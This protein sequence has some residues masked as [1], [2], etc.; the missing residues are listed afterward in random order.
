MA[1][2]ATSPDAPLP[3]PGEIE[4]ILFDLDDTLVDA[5]GSWRAGFAEA[6]AGLHARSPALQRLGSPA[7]IYDGWF[8]RYGEE[9]HRAAGYGE[10]RPGFTSEAFERLVAEHLGPDPALAADLVARYRVAAPR[11][12]AIYPDAEPLL[13][14]LGARYPLG[15]I[16]NG[17]S[18]LQRPKIEQFA[19]ERY[20]EVLVVSGEFGVRKPDPLIFATALEALGVA[21]GRAV[22]IGDNPA[23]DIAG[24]RAAGL[25]AIWVNRGDWPALDPREGAPPHAEV[26]ELREIP[27]LL[28]L[29]GG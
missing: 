25:A 4:A 28:G 1:R 26:R 5:R 18:E 20:F 3:L 13:G 12:I 6:I 11:H 14:L 21:P 8:R 19:L 7:A 23:D 17:P 29:G 2:T 24:A 10:W 27:S 16:S 9:A 15:L 22:F